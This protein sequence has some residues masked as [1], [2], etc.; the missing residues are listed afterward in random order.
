MAVRQKWPTPSAACHKHAHSLDV[1]KG[2]TS[3]VNLG[4]VAGGSLNPDWVEILMGLPIG[5]TDP[6][7]EPVPAGWPAGRGEPQYDYEPPRTTKRRKL[8]KDRL[9]ALGNAV[10][11]QVAQLIARWLKQ[12]HYDLTG[13]LI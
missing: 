13:E 2:P 10:V 1:K 9:K 7:V 3:G 5:W 12:I 6:G 11:P 8:R 4:E